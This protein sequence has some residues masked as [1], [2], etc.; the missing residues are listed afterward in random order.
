[1]YGCVRG[2]VGVYGSAC[3]LV[4]VGVSERAVECMGFGEG[5]QSM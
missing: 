1:M 2:C 4:V 5:D 3:V